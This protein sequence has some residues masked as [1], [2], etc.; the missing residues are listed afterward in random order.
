MEKVVPIGSD[1]AGF[2]LKKKVMEHLTF[3]GFEIRDFG[4]FSKESIDYPDFGH[5]VS[6]F[7]DENKGVLG[8]AGY[9]GIPG[10]IKSV[11]VAGCYRYRWPDHPGMR[12]RDFM[13]RIRPAP[14]RD[15]VENPGTGR[16]SPLSRTRPR[17]IPSICP[18][19]CW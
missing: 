2:E 17:T 5:P 9:P 1:H 18:S 10:R 3:K 8:V 12:T 11:W 16:S 4:C 15:R 7:V 19:G 14:R 6:S 13:G